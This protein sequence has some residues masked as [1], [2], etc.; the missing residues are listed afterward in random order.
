[1][2]TDAS[3]LTHY[4]RI[5]KGEY[6]TYPAFSPCL[7]SVN[8]QRVDGGTFLCVKLFQLICEEQRTK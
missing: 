2:L 6:S 5:E 1:M 3:E 7:G 4:F 8:L